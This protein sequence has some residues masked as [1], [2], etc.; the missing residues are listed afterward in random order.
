M[1][2]VVG[3]ISNSV[4]G[5]YSYVLSVVPTWLGNAINIFLLAVLIVVVSIFIW[6]FYKTLSKVNFINLNLRKYNRVKH[7]VLSK[8]FAVVLYLI[9]NI[10]LMPIL[11]L[12]WFAALAIFL[13]VIADEKSIN[14][15]LILST[16]LV[17]AIRMLS[18]YNEEVSKD[19]AKLF[20]F[21]SLSVF[22]LSPEQLKIENIIGNLSSIPSLFGDI[23]S[24][25]I[26]VLI[27]EI[28]LRFFYSVSEIIKSEDDFGVL[29]ENN[30]I[31]LN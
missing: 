8:A 4:Q 25:L 24:F 12:I 7:P 16:A 6:E 27:I 30:T 9:E 19:V 1:V 14:Q 5:A 31:K 13:L 26:F 20:P 18:Y 21:I 29:R 2:E 3:S 22:L 11:I 15:I 10:L 17:T 28:I 23:I